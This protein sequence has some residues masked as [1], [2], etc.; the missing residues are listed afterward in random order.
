MG[1]VLIAHY[2]EEWELV[3]I[4]DTQMLMVNTPDAGQEKFQNIADWIVANAASRKIKMVAHMGDVTSINSSGTPND[5]DANHEAQLTAASGIIETI[6]D[7][8]VPIL[9]NVGNHD[10]DAAGTFTHWTG[11]FPVARVSGKAW[12]GGRY[13]G[14][15]DND[16]LA[17]L[18]TAGG[19]DYVIVGLSNQATEAE[20]TWAHAIFDTYST[21]IGILTTHVLMDADGDMYASIYDDVVSP[22][23]NVL[24]TLS[25]HYTNSNYQKSTDMGGGRTL[26]SQVRAHVTGEDSSYIRILHFNPRVGTISMTTYSPHLDNWLTDAANQFVW[27]V[28][29]G[30]I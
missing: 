7:A 17:F 16:N 6:E 23:P 30:V 20:R 22:C 4:P 3:M 15:T 21:R 26:W 5:L 9:L 11:T 2:R 1:K 12:Y 24:I 18:F 13:D 29:I 28:G 19:K 27:N 8:N 10:Y 14:D 25:G